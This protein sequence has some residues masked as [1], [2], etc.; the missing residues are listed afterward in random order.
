[1]SGYEGPVRSVIARLLLL[2][3]VLVMPL[4]MAAPAGA[5]PAMD[6]AMM[7]HCP[8]QAPA[9]QQPKGALAACTMACSAALPAMDRVAGEPL[10]PVPMT[11]A[12]APA[13]PLRG[14]HPE[15]ATPPP[16]PA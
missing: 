12:E 13:H 8:D 3:A 15:T 7:S 10:L 4:G 6:M 2:V 16:K 1:M 5:H 9:H 11:I 14:L